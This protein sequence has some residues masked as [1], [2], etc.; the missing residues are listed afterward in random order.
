M[1]TLPEYQE[2]R[3]RLAKSVARHDLH[4]PQIVM[5]SV[6]IDHLRILLA[7]PPV[8]EMVEVGARAFWD[9]H[10][11]PRAK[12]F[13]GIHPGPY[14]DATEMLKEGQRANVRP[15]ADVIQALYRGETK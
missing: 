1:T 11:A 6:P 2:A 10:F 8:S 15:I 13:N 14:D 9:N 12:A 7:G 5:V 4:H 3:E